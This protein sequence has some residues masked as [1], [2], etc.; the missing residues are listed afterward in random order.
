MILCGH[1]CSI[2]PEKNAD[3]KKPN[4]RKKKPNRRKPLTFLLNSSQHLVACLPPVYSTFVLF[5]GLDVFQFTVD[6]ELLTIEVKRLDQPNMGWT[7]D[8]YIACEYF[9]QPESISS[10][11][12]T[13]S[14]SN[15]PQ[16][17]IN[18]ENV[19]TK[20]IYD[21]VGAGW[22][23]NDIGERIDLSGIDWK[24]IMRSECASLCDRQAACLGI[25]F[26]SFCFFSRG[27]FQI[28]LL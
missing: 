20:F 2:W 1:R 15:L 17:T 19:V 14:N 16:P 28:S 5:L 23:V 12:S 6:F 9:S 21:H 22:C 27:V 18:I 4:R 11:D 7:N 10:P 26:L 8:Y 13:N 25:H 24:N 3:K